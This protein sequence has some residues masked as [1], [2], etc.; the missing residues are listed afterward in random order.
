MLDKDRSKYKI[1]VG[2]MK[3][4]DCKELDGLMDG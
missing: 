3:L 4:K 2:L 1:L